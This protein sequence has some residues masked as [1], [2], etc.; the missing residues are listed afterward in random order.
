MGPNP[1]FRAIRFFGTENGWV[2]NFTQSGIAKNF[3]SY[4]N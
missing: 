3:P 1:F 2:G 4:D